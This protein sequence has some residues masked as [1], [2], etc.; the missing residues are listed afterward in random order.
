MLKAFDSGRIFGAVHGDG[1]ARVVALPGWRRTSAD[2]AAVL[3]PLARQGIGSV[4]LDLPGFGASPAP[5]EAWG[6]AD[7]A[8][9]VAAVLPELAPPVIVLGHSHGGGVALCLA[10]GWP[11]AVAGLVVTG[12]PLIRPAAARGRKPPVQFRAARWLHRRGLLSDERME[13]LRR[14]HGSADYRAA[15]GV[16]RDVFVRVVNESYEEQLAAVKCPVELVWAAD[17]AE[18]P[19][20]IAEQAQEILDRGRLTVLPSG[21]HLTPLTQPDVLREKVAALLGQA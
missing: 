10:A 1:P 13:A 17:D 15:T 9:A 11:D 3:E 8:K 5:P 7:Y 14:S 12:S 6:R 4:A 20:A 16:M 21:G 2:F 18:V 19:V